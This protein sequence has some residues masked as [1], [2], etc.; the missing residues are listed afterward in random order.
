VCETWSLI[1]REGHS[2]RVLENK[3]LRRILRPKKGEIIGGWR[4]LHNGELHN[5]YPT[6]YTSI[7]KVNLR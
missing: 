6:P 5:L 2:L 7:M 1:L 3:M 4:K